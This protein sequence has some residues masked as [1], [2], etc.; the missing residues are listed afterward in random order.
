MVPPDVEG[1]VET[2]V[3]DGEYTI[4]DTIVTLL[5]KDDSVKELTMRCV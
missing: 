1:I 5:L 3:P 4:N 2:V